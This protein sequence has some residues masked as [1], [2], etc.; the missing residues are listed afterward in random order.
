VPVYAL[1][2]DRQGRPFYAMRRIQGQTLSAAIDEYH[3]PPPKDKALAP[4]LRGEGGG[5][6]H[7]S[8][9]R[10]RELLRRFV[11]ICQTV[12]Y[13]HA[14]GVLHRDLKPSNVMLGDFGETLV[15]DWGLAKPVAGGQT[16]TRSASE[17]GACQT[18][19][20][21]SDDGAAEPLSQRPDLTA[22]GTQPGSPPYMALEQ[23]EG[24][25]QAIGP[26]TDV[27]GLGAILYHV[28][29]GSAPYSG[30]SR[31]EIIE[32]VRSGPPRKPTAIN[33]TVPRPL[34][35]TC[36][37]AM[38]RAP[39]DRY[40]DPLALAGDVQNWLDD[41][42]VSAY[43][44][45]IRE[46][47]FRWIRHHPQAAV[48]SVVCLLSLS[49]AAAVGTVVVQRE[50]ARTSAALQLA[51]EYAQQAK[52]AQEKA[53]QLDR[54]AEQAR[55]E[56]REHA[57]RAMAA[58]TE[59][60]DAKARIA[61]LQDKIKTG[62]G[63]A[64]QLK[65]QLQTVQAT[66]AA[67]EAQTADQVQK[68]QLAK[69]RAETLERESAQLQREA[70]RLRGLAAEMSR[71]ASGLPPEPPPPPPPA[72]V[73]EDFTKEP[74]LACDLGTGDG[75]FSLMTRDNSVRL[76][77]DSSLR[78]DTLSENGVCFTHPSER[79]A[80]WDLTSQKYLR[81]ALWAPDPK[82]DR[83][84]NV[85]V[86]LGRGSSYVEYQPPA[87]FLDQARTGWVRVAIP[88]SGDA[89][90]QRRETNRPDLKTIDWME[91]HAATN[92]G[93][94]TFWLDDL[95]FSPDAPAVRPELTLNK[96]VPVEATTTQGSKIVLPGGDISWADALVSFTPGDPAPQRS[97]DPKAALGKPDYRGTDDAKDEA[98]YVA[99]GHGG[100]LVLEFADNVLVDGKGPDLAIFEIGPEGYERTLVAISED[101]KNW[102]DVG[103][104]RGSICT[105]DI[106]P[107]VKPGQ[108]FRFVKLTD[109]KAGQSTG[110]WPGAD[111]DAVGAI[112][113]L[114]FSSGDKNN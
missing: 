52:D 101:G 82:K 103:H 16:V 7:S 19:Q 71:L 36:L 49:T 56:S 10:L 60:K 50:R 83:L 12:A 92:A 90:W 18:E 13:A 109:A 62:T 51:A 11:A 39:A 1:G 86:R 102:T 58:T 69:E 112:N 66:L 78:I 107:F 110:E 89:N 35:A 64:A 53:K 70:D 108:R 15:L 94:L 4:V 2:V 31:A 80:R 17:R 26:A 65:E 77:A 88:L 76:T 40:P 106:A 75:R 54:E 30:K 46:R 79:N 8:P 37:K 3:Q 21:P 32:K 23:A 41:E 57:K 42:P 43:P 6:G 33:A 59:A 24:D 73:P 20:S 100:A 25:L 91:L 44:E 84:Q 47:A 98:T 96:V 99:L 55:G 29:T 87:T 5:E 27:Y 45:R 9:A 111:I 74:A 104:I 63:E 68:A 95:G 113:T 14:R 72:P 85:Q 61:V 38:A 81:L 48:A 105:V 93:Q 22:P 97:R 67:A 114:P 34:E 28:L